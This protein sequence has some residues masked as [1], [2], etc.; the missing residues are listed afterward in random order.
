MNQYIANHYDPTGCCRRGDEP[1]EVLRLF[2]DCFPDEDNAITLSDIES[3]LA[4]CPE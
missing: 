4:T 1:S 3:Y 2:L